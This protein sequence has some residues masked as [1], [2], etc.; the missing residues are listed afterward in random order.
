[1][2]HHHDH[3]EPP[4]E[5]IK[6]GYWIT[7][8][9]LLLRGHDKYKDT[10]LEHAYFFMADG[11][12]YIEKAIDIVAK[13]TDMFMME[14]GQGMHLLYSAAEELQDVKGAMPFLKRR[15]IL[16]TIAAGHDQL[17]ILIKHLGYRTI[18]NEDFKQYGSGGGR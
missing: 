3:K 2:T 16:W 1:M 7:Q 18:T 5:A 15:R 17:R 12:R 6:G 14:P 10:S 8:A 13:D 11:L 4:V 9:R